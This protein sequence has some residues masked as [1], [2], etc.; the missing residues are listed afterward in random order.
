MSWQ[1]ATAAFARGDL[2]GAQVALAACEDGPDRQQL[3]ALI[4]LAEG[5]TQ[6]ALASLQALREHYPQRADIGLNLACAL[7]NHQQLSPALRLFDELIASGP[8]HY[9]LHF[10]HALALWRQGALAAAAA[11]FGQ[12]RQQAPGQVEAAVYQA[13]MLAASQQADAARTVLGEAAAQRERLNAELW[14]EIG[15]SCR[16]LA[17]FSLAERAFNQALQLEPSLAA[18]KINLAMLREEEN[19]PD[20][21]R[22]LIDGLDG[23]DPSLALLWA[24]LHRRS[25]APAQAL[26]LLQQARQGAVDADARALATLGFETAQVLDLLGEYPAAFSAAAEANALARSHLRRLTGPSRPAARPPFDPRPFTPAVLA[27]WTQT[28]DPALPAPAFVVGFPRSG[29]TL[30]ERMLARHPRVAV[31]NEKPALQ[32][33]ADAVEQAGWQQPQTLASLNETQTRQLQDVYWRAAAQHVERSPDT[34]LVDKYPLNLV[35]LP[36]IRRVFPSAP[37]VLMLRHPLDACLSCTL[38]DL[39]STDPDQGFWSLADS[40]AIYSQVFS[41]WLA[42]CRLLTPPIFELRYEA[43]V[44]QPEQELRRLCAA[45]A[46]PWDPAILDPNRS[47]PGRIGTPSYA[48]AVGPVR[49]DRRARHRHYADELAGIRRQLQPFLD[50]FGYSVAP[51]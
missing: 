41:D 24:R 36:L 12:A 17:E 13:R 4:Q 18:A 33:L 40:A 15:L 47:R 49:S 11:A 25:G 1:N 37:I 20:E 6:A 21:A 32:Q 43:L 9:S 23:D 31:L 42:Q 35:F 7:M 3:A 14:N 51:D 44:S 27:A 30:L 19:R 28:A 48:A 22:Q 5:Q 29:T 50:A 46:L 34:L 45:L 38:A 10:N 39:R 2:A 8:S 26:A 16:D